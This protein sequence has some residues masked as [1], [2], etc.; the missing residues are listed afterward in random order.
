MEIYDMATIV[1]FS[2]LF[3]REDEVI[4]EI[5]ATTDLKVI[6]DEAVVAEAAGLAGVAASK[7][8]Q[9]FSPKL[10]VFNKF[11]MEKERAIAY[12]KLALSNMLSDESLLLQGHTGLLIPKQ[13][14]HVLK[15]CLIAEMPSRIQSAVIDKQIAE[16]E[17]LKMIRNSDGDSATWTRT[18]FQMRDPWDQSLY[19]MVIPMDK[20]KLFKMRLNPPF[21]QA[22]H[23]GRRL[24]ISNWLPRWKQRCLPRGIMWLLRLIKA[25]L[26]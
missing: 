13:V 20:R 10:S 1:L 19:D 2:G 22:R 18:L 25:L 11:T 12:L 23:P 8:S 26:P 14:S 6:D 21:N 3:C 24:M 5:L 4:E 17:A 16:K 15:V 9:A 7:I